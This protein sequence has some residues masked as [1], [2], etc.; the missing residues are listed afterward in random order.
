[1]FN[2]SA[3]NIFWSSFNHLFRHWNCTCRLQSPARLKQRLVTWNTTLLATAPCHT[4]FAPRG[5][6]CLAHQHP[7]QSDAP[8]ASGYFCHPPAGCSTCQHKGW[9]RMATLHGTCQKAPS[10]MAW[11]DIWKSNETILSI[12]SRCTCIWDSGSCS[13]AEKAAR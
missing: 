3:F 1:M 11:N 10:G 6:P 7:T 2:T 9:P 4:C 13:L 5:S 12:P 8:S